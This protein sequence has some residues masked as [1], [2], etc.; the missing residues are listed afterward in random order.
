MSAGDGKPS[1]R[2][3]ESITFAILFWQFVKVLKLAVEYILEG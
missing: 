2:T 3:H 1:Q